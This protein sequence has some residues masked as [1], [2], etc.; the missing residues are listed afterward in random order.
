M[1]GQ[2]VD[3]ESGAHEIVARESFN[4]KGSVGDI[5]RL[6]QQ[7]QRMKLRNHE[8]VTAILSRLLTKI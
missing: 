1:A 4:E 2:R 3:R 6:L 7:M 5:F 8:S